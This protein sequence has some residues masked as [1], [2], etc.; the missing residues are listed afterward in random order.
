MRLHFRET[1][2][3]ML[4]I[5]HIAA[6]LPIAATALDNGIGKLPKMGYDTFNAFGCDYDQELV[7]AQA[8]AMVKTGLVDAGYNSIIL[9]DCYTEC[10]TPYAR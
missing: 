4:H 10:V 2:H 3:T 1:T 9:D 5:H 7:I 6:L 8:E